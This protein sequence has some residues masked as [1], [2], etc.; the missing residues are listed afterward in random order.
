MMII[1]RVVAAANLVAAVIVTLMYQPVLW[2]FAG[3]TATRLTF[4]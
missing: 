2:L 3:A 1:R 4:H